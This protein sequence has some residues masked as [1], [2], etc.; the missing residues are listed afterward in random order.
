LKAE[1]YFDKTTGIYYFAGDPICSNCKNEIID[2]TAV[3]II[4]HP[5]RSQSYGSLW[6]YHCLNFTK[7]NCPNV[8]LASEIF[9][10]QVGDDIPE[11]AFVMP[12]MRM[13]L[14]TASEVTTF[15]V[16]ISNKG[17][18]SDT[19]ST[20]PIDNTRLA[21]RE[22]WEGSQ[23]GLEPDKV[24]SKNKVLSDSEVDAFLIGQKEALPCIGTDTKKQIK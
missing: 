5:K 11:N 22:S 24:E 15:D 21:G 12:I 6:C 20:V 17:V 23:I 7:K 9:S 3:Y 18:K 1:I 13:S 16:A 10:I 2:E 19:S 4:R 14:S 8:I